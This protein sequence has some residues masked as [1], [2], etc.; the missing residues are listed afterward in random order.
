MTDTEAVE[1]LF[2]LGDRW[3]GEVGEPLP[4][5]SPNSHLEADMAAMNTD[6]KLYGKAKTYEI[7]WLISG[8]TER[9][10]THSLSYPSDSKLGRAGEGHLQFWLYVDNVR[11][12]AFSAPENQL[13]S[14]RL[15]PDGPEMVTKMMGGLRKIEFE[16]RYLDRAKELL[17]IFAGRW[18]P[19][20][21][22]LTSE[23]GFTP[24]A[25]SLPY[26][27]FGIADSELRAEG[28]KYHKHNCESTTCCL[29]SCV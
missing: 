2:S 24:H 8:R 14:V 28:Y 21:Q 18:Q 23:M 29:R 13:R 22:I 16:K 4:S 5:S 6:S 11:T 3:R 19:G 15:I 27:I 12:L 17:K 1:R 26:E 9:V 7:T 10:L 25:S 20:T